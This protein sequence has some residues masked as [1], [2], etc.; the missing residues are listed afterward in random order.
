LRGGLGGWRSI[1][2]TD[3]DEPARDLLAESWESEDEAIR[4]EDTESNEHRQDRRLRLLTDLFCT[5]G[6][7]RAWAI[8]RRGGS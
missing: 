3:D 7:R 5:V 6:A 4:D 1:V 8:G 2:R